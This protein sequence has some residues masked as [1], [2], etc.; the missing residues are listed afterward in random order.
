MSEPLIGRGLPPDTCRGLTRRDGAGGPSDG[1]LARRDFLKLCG[2]GVC[3][4][5]AYRF[6]GG[7]SP[8]R[9]QGGTRGLIKTKLSPFFTPLDGGR[10]R[11]ELCPRRCV[12]A[13]GQRGFCRVRE[14]RD[15][16]YYSLVYGNPCAIH[17][18][19]VEKKPFFH[20][21]PGTTSFS[22]AT[23]GCNLR[24]KFCQNWE[25][26]Q[27]SPEDVTAYDVPPEE[28]VA[29]AR[30]AG[31]R[32]V[33]CTYVEPT[34]FFEYMRD[35][36]ALAKKEGI[37]SV[38]HSN[39]FINPGPQKELC[40]VLDA[41][42]CDLKGF[43]ESYY[44]GMC[45]G[46]LE[47]ILEALKTYRR[48]KVHLELTNL[49]VPTFN[50]DPSMVREMCLWIKKELGADTPVHFTRF[51]PMYKLLNLPATPVETLDKARAAA[52]AA[53]LRYVYVGNVPGHPG[54][55]TYCHRCGKPI[56]LRRGYMVGEVRMKNG[57]CGH[58]GQP[59]P[60][61]WT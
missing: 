23:A 46:R 12:V 54:E 7:P 32:S 39:A 52:L 25:I 36:G 42:N 55:N 57:A 22:L 43:T 50:D 59:I 31:A 14:N 56:I 3:L 28:I 4:L 13:K 44:G 53:G 11:C 10:V 40:R 18:D 41:A 60:G 37:L 8:A 21:L 30:K 15:G 35:I 51:H 20:V 58:C 24:C 2:A 34:I 61:I 9:A 47:P 26:S 29:M 17:L 27:A 33:A 48:E 38:C 6:L 1:K 5:S 16:K 49:M 45:E 19:P